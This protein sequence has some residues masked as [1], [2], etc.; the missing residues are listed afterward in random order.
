MIVLIRTLLKHYLG[1]I[2]F[3]LSLSRKSTIVF[4]LFLIKS[5]GIGRKHVILILEYEKETL[6]SP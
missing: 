5:C 3:L 1:D 2:S 6:L 4:R